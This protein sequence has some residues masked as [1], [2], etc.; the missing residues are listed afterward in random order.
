VTPL[1][2]SRQPGGGRP[3]RGPSEF[4]APGVRAR[5]ADLAA[6]RTAL[7]QLED[8]LEQVGRW[9]LAGSQEAEFGRRLRALGRG[10]CP[11]AWALRV[12]LKPRSWRERFGGLLLAHWA[13]LDRPAALAAALA[14]PDREGGRRSRNEVVSV[15]GRSEPAAAAAWINSLSRLRF[16]GLMPTIGGSKLRFGKTP[17]R[18]SVDNSIREPFPAYAGHRPCRPDWRQARW[19]SR[20]PPG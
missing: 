2:C 1:G 9:P 7:A 15:W 20:G 14:V 12:R 5:R 16:I 19:R 4:A 8:W 10:E 3:P 6:P 13:A 18:V 11:G 17:I